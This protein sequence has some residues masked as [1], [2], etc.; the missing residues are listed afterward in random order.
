[1]TGATV[2]GFETSD[3]LAARACAVG[4]RGRTV[5]AVTVWTNGRQASG[6]GARV[7]R[8][9]VARQLP[10]VRPAPLTCRWSR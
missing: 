1:M 8:S 2:A 10:L 9:V 7:L 6:L 3:S 5:L 4:L